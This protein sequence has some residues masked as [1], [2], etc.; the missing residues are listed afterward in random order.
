MAVGFD[1]KARIYEESGL[2]QKAAGERLLELLAVAPDADVLD[3]GCG[4][5]GMT[6]R[7]AAATAGKVLGIDIS[8]CMVNEARECYMYKDNLEFL[9][10]DVIALDDINAFDLIFCNS[11]FQWFSQPERVMTRCFAALRGGGIIGIQAPATADY[12]PQFIYAMKKVGRNP[13]TGA[14]F[15]HFKS[16]WLLFDHADDY[17]AILNHAGFAVEL[18]SLVTEKARY[19][20]DE[21]YGIFQSGAEN[22]YLNQDYYDIP[23]DEAYIELCRTLIK[24]AFFELADAQG[25]IEL[26][27]TRVYLVAR[28]PDPAL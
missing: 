16:P 6:S 2:V 18:C 3:L 17:Q 26:V 25:L 19:T 22:G 27:F 9:V 23:I 11:A 4:S 21:V 5:G 10:K 15:K 7:I 14:I 20:P 12:C 24:D 13:R 8:E 28:K 1:E